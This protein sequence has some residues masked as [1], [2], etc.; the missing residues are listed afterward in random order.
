[1][2][3]AIVENGAEIDHWEAGQVAARGGFANSPFD[4]R[5]PVPWYRA[6]ENVVDE[7][8]ALTSLNRLHLDAANAELAVSTGLLL[9]L[10]FGV[11]FAANGFAVGDLGG[12][13]REVNVIA[14]VQLGDYDFDVLLA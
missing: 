5:N 12:L 13:E 11:G 3:F 9:V 14:L 8:D 4:G 10:A 6:T 2:I 7:L 1:M